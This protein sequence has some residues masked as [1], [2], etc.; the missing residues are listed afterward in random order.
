MGSIILDIQKLNNFFVNPDNQNSWENEEIEKFIKRAF[1]I[2]KDKTIEDVFEKELGLISL[3]FDHYEFFKLSKNKNAVQFFNKFIKEK[4]DFD[5]VLF[6]LAENNYNDFYW[7]YNDNYHPPIERPK[8]EISASAS[9][10]FESRNTIAENFSQREDET[11]SDIKP[12][13]KEIESKIE[14]VEGILYQLKLKRDMGQE[15]LL[16]DN[17]KNLIQSHIYKRMKDG[18]Y[19]EEISYWEKLL[20]SASAQIEEAN[21][22]FNND[23]SR[24]REFF[25]RTLSDLENLK[26]QILNIDLNE[27]G[28]DKNFSSNLNEIYDDS[29]SVEMSSVYPG[30]YDFE[31]EIPETIEETLDRLTRKIN[32]TINK[33]LFVNTFAMDRFFTYDKDITKMKS[34]VLPIIEEWEEE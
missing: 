11:Q 13:I 29:F 18:S 20:N 5:D 1:L 3:Q 32:I 8:L 12:I 31:E 16:N 34:E 33:D 23:H 4:E 19:P 26:Y 28:V 22:F 21:D 6:D 15:N 14:F 17:I 9:E 24:T 30:S 10:S 2:G 27:F 25:E 7:L